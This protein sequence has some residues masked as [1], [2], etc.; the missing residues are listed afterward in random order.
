MTWDGTVTLGNALTV[1][2][3]LV[4]FLLMYRGWLIWQASVTARL[5]ALEKGK[6]D[7]EDYLV[8]SSEVVTQTFCRAQHKELR[9]D[10]A[11]GAEAVRKAA[12]AAAE[13]VRGEFLDFVKVVTRIEAYQEWTMKSIKV[14]H[15]GGVALANPHPKP[16]PPDPRERED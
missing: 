7:R 16:L 13:K 8:A 15:E 11:T 14:L 2:T 3:L 5:E 9:I 10:A 1:V 6:L 4:G 12:D